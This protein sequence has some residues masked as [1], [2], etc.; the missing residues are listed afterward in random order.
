MIEKPIHKQHKPS[1]WWGTEAEKHYIDGI[2]TK[3]PKNGRPFNRKA[4]RLKALLAYRNTFPLRKV[5]KDIDPKQILSYVS[6]KIEEAQDGGGE[7]QETSE[8]TTKEA[9]TNG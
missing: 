7:T 8:F 5:W 4:Q 1:T 2:G 3:E 6:Q 9:K